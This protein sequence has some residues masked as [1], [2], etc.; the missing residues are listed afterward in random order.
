VITDRAVRDLVQGMLGSARGVE[1]LPLIIH[2]AHTGDYLPMA[3][4]LVGDGPAPPPGAPR[5]VFLSLICSEAIPQV[6]RDDVDRL[7][8]GTFFGD[9]PVRSQMELCADWPRAPLPP[10]FWEPVRA[11]VPVL[12]LA[13]DLDPI[14]PPRYA[15][16][17]TANLKRGRYL[18]LPNRSHNDVDPCVTSLF[19]H[20]LIAGSDAGL[21]TSCVALPAPLRFAT[22]LPA[23]PRQW[24]M[25][26][27][28][29][30]FV[31]ESARVPVCR[32]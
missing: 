27:R 7:T 32:P 14:T 9:A 19:E 13:G 17:V 23:S 15:E 16:L 31:S 5:G 28:V 26:E 2:L 25:I 24:R 8:R 29:A 11:S 20:F 4:A 12:A 22:Q 3:R 1:R 18:L 30:L 6:H 10:D 21:D